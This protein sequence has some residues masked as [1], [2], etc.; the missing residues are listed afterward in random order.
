MA[1]GSS[2]T[3]LPNGTRVAMPLLIDWIPNGMPMMVRQRRAPERRYP[4]QAS[5]GGYGFPHGIAGGMDI[6]PGF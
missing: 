6:D 1:S 4:T 5:V 2:I 3:F